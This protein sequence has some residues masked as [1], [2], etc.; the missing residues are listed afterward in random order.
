MVS[1]PFPIVGIGASAGGI[2]ALKS[3][4]LGLP[5]QPGIA[6]VIV[7]H[8]NPV[9]ESI[10]NEVVA[11][12]TQLP[13]EVAADGAEVQ[14]DHV[15]VMPADAILS[16]QNGHLAIHKPTESRERKPVDIFLSS[17]AKD[18]G[19]RAVS[20][21]L[22]G[23]DGDGTL[24]TKAVKERGG[25]TLAQVSDGHSP[26]H[27]SMP[28]GAIS[29]G[30]VDF[31]L[32]A[33]EMGPRL[34]T[35][36][37]GLDRSLVGD[38]P[39]QVDEEPDD[40]SETRHEICALLRNQV[41]HDF[42]G[43]KIR[44]FLR[45]V[46]RRVEVT[47]TADIDAYL[48]LLRQQPK[49]VTALFRDLLIN[50]TD[51][52]RDGD[53]F[54]KLKELVIPHLFEGRVGE[55]AVR[56][57]VPG[58]AT[59]EEVYSIAIL[60]REQMETLETPPRVQIFA[61]DIH[62]PSLAVA[63]AGRYPDALLDGVSVERRKRF[64]VQE[65]GCH[66][67][68]KSLR[69]LCIFSPHSLIRNPPFSRIDLISCRNLLIYFDAEVQRRVI[70]TF[71]YAL[72]QGGYLF[73]GSTEH[74]G[75]FSDLFTPL[76]KK[77]RIFRRR[78]HEPMSARDFPTGRTSRM[79]ETGAQV[80]L[81]KSAR[82]G[83][84]LRL[85]LEAQLLERFVPPHVVVNREAD[86]VYFSPK[87]GK[88]LEPAPGAPS[89]Q[90]LTLARRG[91]R[92]DLRTT[93]AQALETGQPATRTGVQVESEDGHVQA[94]TLTVQPV[95]QADAEEPL[96]IVL[97]I[98][99]APPQHMDETTK[100]AQHPA[101]QETAH[102][103]RELRDTRERLQSLVEEY[104]SAVEE[105]KSSNEELLS[106]NEELHASNEELE[107]S[108]EELQSLNEE[109]NTVNAELSGKVEALDRAK[110]DLENLLN[111]T[112]VAMVFMNENLEIRAYT[113]AV[114]QM[115][116]MLP[117]DRGRPLT[118]LRSRIALPNLKHDVQ[119]V[120]ATGE[121]LERRVVHDANDAYL[122]RL[123]P[124]KDHEDKIDG[125]VMTLVDIS[126]LVAAE[127]RQR[128]LIAELNH[129]VKNMLAV[130]ISIAEL[131]HKKAPSVAAFKATFVARLQSMSRAYEL[132]ASEAWKDA[133]INELVRLELAPFGLERVNLSGPSVQLAAKQALSIG[134]VLHELATNA[135]KYGSLSVEGG[136]V[137]VTWTTPD[138]QDENRI[139][140]EWRELG[141][142]AVAKPTSRGF[143]LNLVEREAE[144]G[145]GGTANLEFTP[146]GLVAHVAIK[147]G[148]R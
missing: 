31:A 137:Q 114:Q 8:L 21:I 71:H 61:T 16:M 52:F 100:T 127:A 53:A 91:L 26:A 12:F 105:L 135:G 42:S 134:M 59:G 17:L 73:L 27:P 43:Y 67:V 58:C 148:D 120:H 86:V 4:F 103:E 1:R 126:K 147:Q 25:L 79:P 9:R 144:F 83:A 14:V 130:V 41:G 70:P 99:E 49:E 3:F 145:L 133:S 139:D 78:D 108:K 51:F 2:E 33:Q 93:F 129:R 45:R 101:T 56:I 50:V 34:V 68:Q 60:V 6:I 22:S 124:Y 66:V 24:G 143:G 76:D 123:T 104:E 39:K 125:V 131:T 57:W 7:T 102:L 30:F 142:P 98:D 87:T 29:T 63:R 32:P 11:H 77:Q 55:D 106:V 84:G 19:E 82:A 88:Y 40:H 15:Y 110:S 92:L 115:F 89:P 111:S 69:D 96:F 80:F 65:D 23:G 94:I 140:L 28:E 146:Q 136:T 90:L 113:P 13:V 122:L 116:N 75:A 74:I 109:L 107:A 141:G 62:E 119:T 117:T 64:F 72:R 47:Q 97:F 38:K 20:V 121:P 112:E 54:E 44:T 36:A 95:V 5:P 46:Q 48:A 138:A 35:F 118:D 85:A 37:R 18:Q 81:R 132:L 10:L 128:V